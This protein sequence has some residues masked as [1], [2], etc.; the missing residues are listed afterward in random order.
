MEDFRKRFWRFFFFFFILQVDSWLP[1]NYVG[2]ERKPYAAGWVI[3]GAFCKK[4]HIVA[5]FGFS[6]HKFFSRE[7]QTLC[8]KKNVWIFDGT[9][10]GGRGCLL[11]KWKANFNMSGVVGWMGFWLSWLFKLWL[12]EINEGHNFLDL[13]NSSGLINLSN[14]YDILWLML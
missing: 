2:S 12:E 5:T 10:S 6:T 14:K 11:V 1:F 9:P 7:S 3:M 4:Y 13:Y 8:W